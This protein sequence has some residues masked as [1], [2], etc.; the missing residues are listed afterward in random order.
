MR[1]DLS[2]TDAAFKRYVKPIL[3]LA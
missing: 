3:S 1:N 2:W